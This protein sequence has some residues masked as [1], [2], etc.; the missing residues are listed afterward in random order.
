MTC[1]YPPALRESFPTRWAV[2]IGKGKGNGRDDDEWCCWMWM[3]WNLCAENEQ[4]DCRSVVG[5]GWC[6][7]SEYWFL[8]GSALSV[9]KALRKPFT[10]QP[11]WTV[12][13]GGLRRTTGE[14]MWLRENQ[15]YAVCLYRAGTANSIMEPK[16]RKTCVGQKDRFTIRATCL[17]QLSSFAKKKYQ[18]TVG[19]GI[20]REYWRTF[21]GTTTAQTSYGW[22]TTT[23]RR[24]KNQDSGINCWASG[25][26][27]GIF[28]YGKLNTTTKGTLSVDIVIRNL[29]QKRNFNLTRD[30]TL[31]MEKEI[32]RKLWKIAFNLIPLNKARI[33]AVLWHQSGSP[34]SKPKRTRRRRNIF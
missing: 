3:M 4:L 26:V 23:R 29:K 31:I 16:W 1:D 7:H 33:L 25:C 15:W 6:G 20:P 2:F 12:Y 32:M 18:N 11:T 27:P 13:A 34:S 28:R 9:E 10:S 22:G 21:S 30:Y 24:R 19:L 17:I 5:Y 14:A 8:A